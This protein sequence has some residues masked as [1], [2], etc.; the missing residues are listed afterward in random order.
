MAD[1]P[2]HRV[3]R[4][5]QSRE[6]TSREQTLRE[7]TRKQVKWLPASALPDVPKVDGWRYRWVRKSIR[8]FA[9]PTNM[10]KKRREGWEPV[11]VKEH[12]ELADYIDR[13]AGNSGLI[14]IGGLVLHRIPEEMALARQQYFSAQ[15][16]QVLQSA[17]AQYSNMA[18]PVS[19]MPLIRENKSSVK[20]GSGQ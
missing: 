14:E 3:Q 13:D 2:T 8:G 10:G 9:D 12:P 5:A 16:K 18:Q 11:N 17:E 7:G 19:S 1:M 15:Q 4:D 6:N 20:F